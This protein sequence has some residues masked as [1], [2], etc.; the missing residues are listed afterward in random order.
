MAERPPAPSST[1]ARIWRTVRDLH[2][3]R[4]LTARRV[5][6][7][8]VLLL[9]LTLLGM[10]A[11]SRAADTVASL[12]TDEPDPVAGSPF[13]TVAPTAPPSS[14]SPA[15]DRIVARDRLIVA[16]QEVPGLVELAPATGQDTGF[17][18]ALL[19]LVA[20]DLGV[21][22]A[23]TSY[24]PLA[25]DSRAAALQR[26]E[27][28]VVAGGYEVPP[29]GPVAVAGPYLVLPQRLAVPPGSTV[30][31]LD[32]LGGGQVCAV[33]GSAA[34]ES[35][36]GRLGNALVTRGSVG[37]CEEILSTRAV[38]VAADEASLAGTDLTPV[39]PPLGE[40][41]Y[42]FGLSPGDDV[43]RDRVQSALRR[44]IENGTWAR[45]Y[46]EHLGTPVPEPPPM[47]R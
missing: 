29:E 15:L 7:G 3:R 4:V 2:R 19:E 24:K 38:A 30:T 21:D 41:R 25:G 44:A 42:G 22:P 43:L 6:C 1:T 17:D 35:L 37:S 10:V 31:G 5:G 32:S 14:G 11:L 16:V 34:A 33:E 9:V 18:V 45:L 8:F 23:R 26:G 36:A 20:R 12:F 13:D 27:A 28:D 39:G 40:T 47:G 46:A